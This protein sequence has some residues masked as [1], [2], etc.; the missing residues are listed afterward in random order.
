MSLSQKVIFV[1]VV[2]FVSNV[3]AFAFPAFLDMFRNDPFRNPARDGCDTCHMSAAGGDDRNEF[4]LAFKDAGAFTPMM[5][6]QFPDRFVYPTMRVSDS[7]TIHFSDPNKKQIVIQ[8]GESARVLVDVDQTSVDG[9]AASMPGVAAAVAAATPGQPLPPNNLSSEDNGSDVRVDD[10]AR[11]GAFFGMNV[12]NL[13]N[14]KPQNAGGVDFWVGH[15]FTQPAFNR[16]AGSLFGL[17]SSAR[18]GFG[19]RVG[20]TDRISVSAMRS[21]L[22]KTVELSSMFQVSRQEGGVPVTFQIRAGIEGRDNFQE[23]HSPYLQLVTVRT[24]FDRLSLAFVPT[25]AFATRNED[26]FFPPEFI[27][28]G[29]HKHTTALGLGMGLR[30][31]PSTSLVA[32]YIPRVHGFRGELQDRPGVSVA[33]QK[34]T[35]RHTFEIALSTQEPMTASQY[36]VQGTDTFRIGFNIYRKIR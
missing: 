6:A 23:R 31:L 29:E 21:N 18:I 34:S 22:D 35:F 26:T 27:F 28:G 32:E 12:V 16:A 3:S 1:F 15:R 5:R 24:F 25:F 11:E 2:F 7:L 10:Y 9:R 30:I 19:V 13:P 4:G 8:T 36:S 14:G 33:L 20:L 17:D